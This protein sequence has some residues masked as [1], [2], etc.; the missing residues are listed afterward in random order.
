MPYKSHSVPGKRWGWSGSRRM[1][2]KGGKEHL[3]WFLWEEKS[4]AGWVV[5]GLVNF[6]NF[7]RLWGIGVVPGFLI[8]GP[9]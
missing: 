1:E 9:G 3:L 2:G 7:S 4:E 6:N 8:S 5:L